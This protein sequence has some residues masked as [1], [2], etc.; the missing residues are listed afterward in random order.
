M[1]REVENLQ[2]FVL[3]NA[4]MLH[5]ILPQNFPRAFHLI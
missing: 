1:I 3:M 2:D 5:G 4:D